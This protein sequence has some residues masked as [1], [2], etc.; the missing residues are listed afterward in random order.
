MNVELVLYIMYIPFLQ[1][2]N[3][4]KIV[5][6]NFRMDAFGVIGYLMSSFS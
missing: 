5:I 2:Q 4:Q 3:L 1:T 6:G